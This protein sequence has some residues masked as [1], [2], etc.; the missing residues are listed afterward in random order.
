MCIAVPGKL[1]STDGHIGRVDFN[2]NVV[3]ALMGAVD[4]KP[5]DYVL[6]HAGC[7]IEVMDSGG[8]E[9]ILAALAELDGNTV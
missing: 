7:A 6:I 1:I 2:G 3:Q 4:A 9:E 5:G 8:A